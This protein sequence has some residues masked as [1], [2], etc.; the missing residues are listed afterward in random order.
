V[1]RRFFNALKMN[2]SVTSINLIGYTTISDEGA[3]AIAD[4]L[5]ANTSVTNIYLGGNEIGNEGALT[6]ADAL[7]V[8]TTLL[9]SILLTMILA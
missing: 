4:A 5:K 3:S 9:R 8:N 1:H 2:A 7:K 6:L